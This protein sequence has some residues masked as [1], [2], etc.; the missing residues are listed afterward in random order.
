LGRCVGDRWFR[1]VSGRGIC[2]RRHLACEWEDRFST[3]QSSNSQIFTVNPNGSAET[4]I[5]RPA[6]GQ[7]F[8]PTWSPDGSKIIFNGDQT[9]TEQIY[10]MNADGSV[11]HLLVHDP[12]FN[13]ANARFSPNGSLIAFTR[14]SALSCPAVMPCQEGVLCAIYVVKADGTGPLTRLTSPVWTSMNPS[15]SPD[16]KQIAFDSNRNGLLSAVWV[17]NA[18]GTNQRQLTAAALEANYPDWSPDGSHILFQDLCCLFGTN[19]WVMI[20]DGTRQKQ[21]TH[22]PTKH[23]DGFASYSPD[24]KKIVLGADLAYPPNS[25]PCA[26][27]YTMDT[28]GTHM[29]KIVGNQPGVFFSAWGPSP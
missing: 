22:M 2:S 20:A 13:D 10:E 14:C 21:L 18:N 25:C 23:Q 19:I 3:D 4:L 7:A 15:W 11:R 29:T 24:G 17:M 6:D 12:G 9:G 27:L 16:G 1:S 5:T 26:D 8:A 28:N